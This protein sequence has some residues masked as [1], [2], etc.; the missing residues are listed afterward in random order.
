MSGN[1]NVEIRRPKGNR[2]P[3]QPEH[4]KRGTSGFG[5]RDS[6]GFRHSNFGFIPLQS[7]RGGP[8]EGHFYSSRRNNWPTIRW[9]TAP[10]DSY[11]RRRRDGPRSAA[12]ERRGPA[13][14]TR[15]AAS[16][17]PSTARVPDAKPRHTR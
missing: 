16:A 13:L 10:R 4:P 17:P 15:A 8:T 2:S 7:G 12:K 1:P 3:K 6:F 9:R 14:A 5:F 11:P